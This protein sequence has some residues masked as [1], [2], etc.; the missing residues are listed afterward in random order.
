[1]SA[2]RQPSSRTLRR[3]L[4]EELET[5]GALTQPAVRAAFLVVPRERFLPATQA[6]HGL[7]AVYVNKAVVTR[8]GEGGAP[9]SSSSQP[10]I[11]APMLER[12]ELRRGHRVLEIG[13]GTGYNAAL[14]S[15]LVGDTGHVVSVELQPDVAAEA[16]T[17]LAAGG[18][19]VEVVVGDGRLGWP[20]GALYDRIVA[21]AS[22][23]V[24]PRQWVD[25]LAPDGLLEV[26]VHLAGP[27][28]Q[29]VV[30]FRRH[31]DGLRSTSVLGGGFMVLRGAEPVADTDR[32]S[33]TEWVGGRH[34]SLGGLSGDRLGNLRPA[35]R[36]R[37]ARLML[38]PPIGRT[39]LGPFGDRGSPG[40]FLRLGRPKGVV[41]LAY[42]RT[43]LPGPPRQPVAAA[44]VDGR[45][46]A[47]LSTSAGG[48]A[49][50]ESYGDPRA[51]AVVVSR[52]DDWKACG[53]PGHED[54]VVD[55]T[56]DAAGR[57][58]ITTGWRRPDPG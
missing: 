58:T 46:L 54:L 1:V 39:R 23:A 5:T 6:A 40:L 19:P 26:P 16:R 43:A 44:T 49:Q 30:T 29:A 18:H 37:L 32:I 20:A 33:V 28:L 4:V 41:M 12:L 2:A 35:A 3:R 15:T 13:A 11:M 56:F 52:L 9:T 10:A 22:T 17:A 42:T 38:E 47:V 57:S 36:D 7:S 45:S 50:I 14:L 48:N 27:D 31:G 55:V 53:R 34:R 8:T 25:Q 21:T 24:V 51:A